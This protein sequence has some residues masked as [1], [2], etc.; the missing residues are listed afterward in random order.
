MMSSQHKARE[1]TV[2]IDLVN[3]QQTPGE[4]QMPND[5]QTSASPKEMPAFME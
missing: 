1:G 5:S 3:K 2:K 4:E